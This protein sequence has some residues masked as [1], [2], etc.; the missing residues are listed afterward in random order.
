VQDRRSK[1]LERWITSA[2]AIVAGLFIGLLSIFG[3]KPALACAVIA[4]D[5]RLVLG[6][7]V[8]GIRV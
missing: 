3:K 2:S 6:K 1:E 5:T 7:S 8:R 4:V